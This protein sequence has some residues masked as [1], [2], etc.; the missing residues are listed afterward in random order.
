MFEFNQEYYLGK[1]SNFH[2]LFYAVFELGKPLH[3]KQ[4]ETAAVGLNTHTGE[5]NFL[6]NPD[7]FY[8]L[9]EQEQLF[10]ICH[11]ALHIVLSHISRSMDY[12]LDP[13]LSN[14][15]QDIVINETLVTDFGFHR[16]SLNF[17]V[18][19]CFIDT[20]FTK[21]QINKYQIV[22]GKSFEFYYELLKKFEKYLPKVVVLDFHLSN[23]SGGGMVL[24]D[25]H[26]NPIIDIP[27]EISDQLTSKIGHQLT[28]EE[29]E[30]LLE[31]LHENYE[32]RGSGGYGRGTGSNGSPLSIALDEKKKRPWVQL[33][34]KK[35]ATL[36]K[37]TEKRNE[38]FKFR[39]RRITNL[40]EDLH[41]PETRFD[42]TKE[43][44]KFNI[45]FFLDASGSCVRHKDKF[46]NLV[47][48]IPEDKFYVT[49][50]SFDSSTYRLDIKKPTVKGGGGTSFSVLEKTVQD[51]IKTDK[52]F[53]KKYPD[54]V[55]ILSDGDGDQVFPEKPERWYFLLTK[56]QTN[57]IPKKAN[58]ILISDFTRGENK[59]TVKN[60]EYVSEP[61]Y[62]V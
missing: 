39:P 37:T 23:D 5:I 42:E 29:I 7:F 31:K 53:K 50:F 21:E 32:S 54:L 27:Q 55:F 28:S 20:V 16:K 6:I 40:S 52:Q 26:G 4:I 2:R 9:G 43:N 62:F 45:V 11:E 24:K 59:I 36:Q 56:N 38:T 49:L 30:D 47:R 58:V 17:G 8:K 61:E 60:L 10:I 41:L 57:C 14:I 12:K 44:D 46:F 3:T 33:I 18:T 19:L 25:E 22:H 1:L 51:L 35:I 34:K 15:A 48:T 13:Q